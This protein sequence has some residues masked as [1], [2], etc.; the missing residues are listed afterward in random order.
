MSRL[1][2][3]PSPEDIACVRR[4]NARFAEAA[5]WIEKRVWR[6][7]EAYF[8]GGGLIGMITPEGGEGW[9][10]YELD[11]LVQCFLGRSDPN[12]NPDDEYANLVA[13]VETNVTSAEREQLFWNERDPGWGEFLSH[14]EAL[15]R[16][17]FCLLF[18]ALCI[19]ELHYDF[20]AMRSIGE[21]ET[22]LILRRQRG[23]DLDSALLPRKRKNSYPHGVFEQKHFS[24]K[25]KPLTWR[26]LRYARLL[27]QKMEGA[28]RW[29]AEQARRSESEYAGFAGLDACITEDHA[30]EY[31]EMSLELVGALG[32]SHP[33][34]DEDDDNIVVRYEEPICIMDRHIFGRAGTPFHNKRFW[35]RPLSSKR[36]YLRGPYEQLGRA[37]PCGLFRKVFQKLDHDWLKLLS[38]GKLWLDV[39]FVQHRIIE[40]KQ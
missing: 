17:P 10:D 8:A 26:E 12:F 24:R 4:L 9:E 13:A 7:Q 15:R 25:F 38:I 33:E 14:A 31:C 2:T 22:S 6:T 23:L 3:E 39:F 19:D 36:S 40:V 11:A 16:E 27:N 5:D 30:Y 35:A 1:K 20:E 29:F 32:E 18:H 28:G 37:R 21:I 34:F